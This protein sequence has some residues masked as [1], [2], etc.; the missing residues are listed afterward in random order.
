MLMAKKAEKAKNSPTKLSTK[1]QEG[2]DKQT[3]QKHFDDQ[4]DDE[5]VLF[6]F[7]KHPVVMRKGLIL[8]MGA[9]LLGTVPALIKPEMSYFFGG[10]AG[11]FL[12]GLVLF[13]PSWIG[14]FYSVFIVTDQRLIQ[15]TQK[16]LFHR[17]VVDLNLNQIQMVNYQIGGFQETLLGF[18]TIMM[19]TYVG[20]LVIHNVHHPAKIQKK[21]LTILRDQGVSAVSNPYNKE[22]DENEEETE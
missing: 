13:F 12:L 3:K 1:V 15:I 14:W 7:R 18:G 19:Q 11:G 2:Q 8:F 17:S 6:V 20:D 9:I 21:I 22:P 5:D 10:L 16:G 4:F